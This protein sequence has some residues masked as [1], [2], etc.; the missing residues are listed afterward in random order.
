[1]K[2]QKKKKKEIK[3]GIF[4]INSLCYFILYIKLNLLKY[5]HKMYRRIILISTTEWMN[6]WW[7]YL[8]GYF[9]D[10]VF[11]TREGLNEIKLFVWNI[12]NLF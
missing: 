8:T 1:M 11:L 6:E 4:K 9:L 3:I 5:I 12:L 2:L 7:D 10:F